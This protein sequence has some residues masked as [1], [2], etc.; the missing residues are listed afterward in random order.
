MSDADF[1]SISGR[2]PVHIRDLPPRSERIAARPGGIKHRDWNRHCIL[3]HLWDTV[4]DRGM[5][6][7]AAFFAAAGSR[8]FAGNGNT[9]SSIFV[10]RRYREEHKSL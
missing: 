4:H 6:L 3:D 7:A 2:T 9:V 8:P 10:S 5:G 1:T